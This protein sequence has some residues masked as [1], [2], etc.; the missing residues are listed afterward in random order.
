MSNITDGELAIN[1]ADMATLVFT[2][3]VTVTRITR[4]TDT[5]TGR[6]TETEGTV[7]TGLVNR[8]PGI[9]SRANVR[10]NIGGESIQESL[11]YWEFTFPVGVDVQVGDRI[12]SSTRRYQV[13]GVADKSIQHALYVYAQ[14]RSSATPA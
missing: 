14:E 8:K 6:Y 2:E 4:P 1:R 10:G 9:E 11:S 3:M 7:W 5:T 13:I 12:D